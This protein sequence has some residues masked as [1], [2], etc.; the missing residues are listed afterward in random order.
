ML[1]KIVA[2]VAVL[3]L[4]VSFAGCKK[5]EEKPQL[6]AGHPPMEGGMPPSGMPNMPKVDRKVIVSRDVKA[7]W[8]AVKIGV[9]DK[10]AKINKEYTI[11]VGSEL[12]IPNTKMTVK[13]LNFLPDF[14]MTDTEF[15]SAS[16]KPNMPAAQVVVAENGKEIWSNWLFSLQ[17]GI[18]PF[19]HENIG[20]M[21]VGGVS[22]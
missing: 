14:K 12:A 16:D 6:P 15:T 2:V 17:P 21:L 13:V 18:H 3:V 5:K 7:K 1:K 22:K 19:Q 10:K 8:K 4:A 11:N 20:L 9:E